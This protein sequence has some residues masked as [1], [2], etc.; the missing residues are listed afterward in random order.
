MN[1]GNEWENARTKGTNEDL[2]ERKNEKE[3]KLNLVHT[4]K[5]K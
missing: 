4:I 2:K 3:K 1:Q 5:R